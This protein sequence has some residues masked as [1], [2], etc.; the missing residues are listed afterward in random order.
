MLSSFRSA[1]KCCKD[2]VR[3]LENEDPK[4]LK[5]EN[6]DPRFFFFFFFWGGG[7]GVESSLN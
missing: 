3:C 4:D 5:L 2:Q 1:R 7:G 6:E